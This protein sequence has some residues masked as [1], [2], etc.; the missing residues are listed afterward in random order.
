MSVPKFNI[1]PTEPNGA[2]LWHL[3]LSK[4]KTLLFK[5][6]PRVQ[7]RPL[8]GTKTELDL[9]IGTIGYDILG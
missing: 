3:I 1:L 2:F 8:F 5:F 4:T 7:A 9:K 6:Q